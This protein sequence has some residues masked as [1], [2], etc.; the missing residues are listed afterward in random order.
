VGTK[1]KECHR[2]ER[3]KAEQKQSETDASAGDLEE[4]EDREDRGERM[5]AMTRGKGEKEGR[6]KERIGGDGDGEGG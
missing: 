6:K 5:G 4:R 2:R 1:D 3:A